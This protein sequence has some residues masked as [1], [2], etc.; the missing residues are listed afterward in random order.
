MYQASEGVGDIQLTVL[1]S[2]KR[3]YE[4]AHSLEKG[5]EHFLI[6]LSKDL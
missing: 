4:N 5:N 6:N 3:E 2:K 1:I